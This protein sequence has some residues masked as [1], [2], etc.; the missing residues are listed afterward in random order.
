[1]TTSWKATRMARSAKET[2]VTVVVSP[3]RSRTAEA[4]E[5]A[6]GMITTVLLCALLVSPSFAQVNFS[7][8]FEKTVKK[9]SK[10]KI[11][12]EV[13]NWITE[14]DPVTGI[15]ARDLISQVIDNAKDEKAILKG[16]ANVMTTMLFIGGVKRHV[17]RLVDEYPSLLA[18]ADSVGWNREELI[19]YSSLYFY[20]SERLKYHLYVSKSILEMKQENQSIESFRVLDTVAQS[21]RKWTVKMSSE[22][23]ALRRNPEAPD[24]SLDVRALEFVQYCFSGI[25]VEKGRARVFIDSALQSLKSTYRDSR[26]H[27]HLQFIE[28]L[29]SRDGV[30]GVLEALFKGYL[31]A[32]K[33]SYV[34]NT[35]YVL[36]KANV[37]PG[38]GNTE[39][40]GETP[41]LNNVL[42]DPFGALITSA[43]YEYVDP[44]QTSR[45]IQSIVREL[46]EIWISKGKQGGWKIEYVFA[47]GGT[48]FAGGSK[49]QV[50]FTVL[51]QVRIVH[52][53]ESSSIYAFAG[54]FFD[55]I[56]KN[57][58]YKEGLKLYLA[59]IGCQFGNTS[60]SLDAGVPYSDLKSENFRYGVSVGYEIPITD[61]FD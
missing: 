12:N 58:L 26:E 22:L 14:Q 42:A 54:G 56:V 46:I 43:R 59:G 19:A 55:P 20:Y 16:T 41:E 9:I 18:Q 5:I 35:F 39:K 38:A 10:E 29:E 51:D 30:V 23:V 25:L 11:K 53:W 37:N 57:T 27:E 31:N 13:V 4:E 1:M 34:A 32:Y 40:G 61:V 17:S 21:E 48:A 8:Q 15:V 3:L 50:D 6:K 28:R 33:S 47:L 45:I 60:F 2:G 49:A 44:E 36:N 52:H 24:I 7:D